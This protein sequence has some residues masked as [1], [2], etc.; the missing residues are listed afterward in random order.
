MLSLPL[1]FAVLTAY[2]L[3]ATAGQIPVVNGVIGGAPPISKAD[4]QSHT[5]HQVLVETSA[6]FNTTPGKL[7]VVENSGV[8]E[9]TPGVYQASGYGDLSANESMWFW[10][11]EARKNPE[12]APLVLWLNGG[13]GSSSM[14]GLFQEH[15][16]CRITNDSSTVV[17]NPTSWNEVA[18][19]LY[20]DQ[21]IGVGFSHGSMTVNSS[22]TAAS[23]M[24]KFLQIFFKDSRFS[25]Y[26]KNEFALWTESYGGHYGPVFSAHFLKQNAGITNGTVSGVPINL[27]AL[28]IGNGITDPLVQYPGYLTYAA[29][30]PYHPLVNQSVLDT[31]TAAWEGFL[32]CKEVI[33]LCYETNAD[34]ACALAQALCNAVIL[35]PLVGIYDFYYVPSENPDPYPADFSMYINNENITSKIGAEV[36]WMSLKDAVFNNFLMTGDWMRNKRAALE[37]VIDAGVRTLIFDGDADYIANFIGVEAMVDALQTQFTDKYKQ[38][39]FANYTVRGQPAG[40]Y[41]NAGTF[42]YVRVFG[43]G[44]LVPAY[45][46]GALE[47]G[48]AALQI[49]T[50]IMSGKSLSPT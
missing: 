26:Q 12:N 21:P 13:P 48:E 9:T 36:E 50:Q 38:Q 19:M 29:S 18:N 7:R 5:S 14:L 41:K 28:A 23:D 16:P 34:T 4:A 43:A 15:G 25:K 39:S 35:T 10:F 8:C 30:N 40:I 17:N 2:S 45:K 22:E 44:H 1:L 32:G 11:F 31:A 47:Y 27:K 33:T 46:F 42:S 24:W 37:T 3:P 20:I 6:S 49:F